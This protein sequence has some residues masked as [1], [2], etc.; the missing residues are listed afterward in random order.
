MLA[1][2]GLGEEADVASASA[3]TCDNNR[4]AS[5]RLSVRA[6][7][8]EGPGVAGA[9]EERYEVAALLGSGTY[10]SAHQAT[11]RRTGAVRAV[12]RIKVAPKTSQQRLDAELSI[13][14]L[15]DHPN[16][17]RLF[18][19]FRSVEGV[20]MV[21]ELCTGGELFERIVSEAPRGFEEKRAASY[22]RQILASLCYLHSNH[23]AHRDVKPENFLL[24]SASPDASLKLID[25]GLAAYVE[26]KGSLSTRVG[27]PYYVAP[28]VLRG[29]YDER[30]DVWSAGVISYVMLV[31]Y[32]PFHGKSDREV[33]RRVQRGVFEFPAEDW[34]VISMG[35]KALVTETLTLDATLRPSAGEALTSLWL[36]QALFAPQCLS[37]D[38]TDAMACVEDTAAEVASRLRGSAPQRR[39]C[40]SGATA[41]GRLARS[42]AARQLADSEIRALQL[43]FQVL[44]RN[45]DGLLSHDELFGNS[46]PPKS[47]ENSFDDLDYTEFLAATVE[48]RLLAQREV[49]LAAFATFDLDGD[50]KVTHAEFEEVL[51][52]GDDSRIAD[53]ILEADMDGDGCISYD[54]FVAALKF[55]SDVST[56][57]PTAGDC[58]EACPQEERFA[59]AAAMVEAG[60]PKGSLSVL[61]SD[62][63][64]P[65][66]L[67]GDSFSTAPSSSGVW[68][69]SPQ[70]F[71]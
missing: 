3:P 28:E 43:V 34:D 9:L 48:S 36:Q 2:M 68:D 14:R 16:V 7:A 65:R 42:A 61:R 53:M 52:T 39:L 1:W 4:Q 15:M 37:A 10:G 63:E 12:K 46:E 8:R 60:S 59:W 64:K 44:D 54:E 29:F 22:S 45:G 47:G 58:S 38:G 6:C 33:L 51:K 21:M 62:D 18:E 56:P 57:N 35:A 26:P 50:G 19:T 23:I 67:S 31:G 25:F 71:E 17:V 13:A 69:A 24:S 55:V 27:T 20:S 30:C 66:G 5:R 32:P 41:L 11:C 70:V 40:G 49:C